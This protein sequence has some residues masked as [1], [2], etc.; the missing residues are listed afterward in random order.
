MKT[1][2][3]FTF[4]IAVLVL[5]SV[6]GFSQVNNLC[7][8]ADPFCT[9]TTYNFPAGV[10]AGTAEVG[11]NYG[12]LYSQ[13]NPAW[14]Y[15]QV[16][17]SGPIEIYMH[18][19][20]N[21]DIDFACWGPFTSPTAPCVAQLTAG[22]NTP[23]HHAPGASPDYPSGN[24]IDCSYSAS[25]EEWCYIPNAVAGQYYILMITNYSNS[26]Q[27]IIFS[28]TGGAGATNCG[29]LAPPIVGDTVCEG[30]TIQ[31]TVTNPTPG[32]SYSWT[33]PGGWTSSVMNPTIPASTLAMSG[34]YSMI[35]TVGTQVSPA[36]TCTVV[37]NPNP[38]ISISP[39]NPSTCSGTAINLTG[40]STTGGTNYS[41]SNGSGTNPNPVNPTTPTTYTVT[42]TDANGCTGTASVQVNINPDLVLSVTP[43]A[44]M[45]CIG[46]SVDLT[47]SGADD[48]AWAPSSGLSCT[49]C[50]FTTAS[51]VTTTTYVVFGSDVN[52]CTGSTS[53]T[54]TAS[55][56]P[57]IQITQ[58]DPVIC[59][60]DTSSLVVNGAANCTWSPVYGLNT[61]SGNHVLAYPLNTT[62]YTVT[63]DNNGCIGTGEV[64]VTV[65]MSP[66][67][68][69]S[70]DVTEGCEK[71]WVSFTDNTT[72][73]VH[74][75]FWNF[76]DNTTANSSNHLQ[77]PKH[78]FDEPGSYDVT[79]SVV[80][81]DGCAGSMTIPQM[82][83]IHPDPI[84]DFIYNPMV[85]DEL[86]Q[87]I[88]FGDQSV[89]ASTW[90]WDFGE[91]YILGNTSNLPNPTHEYDGVGTYWVTLAIMS[92]FGC[93]DTVVK[94][95]V[96]EPLITFYAP[97]SFTPN[98][99]GRNDIFQ[100][101]GWGL[102]E[103]TFEIRI[104]DRWGTQVYF[105][106]DINSGWDGRIQGQDKVCPEG[107]YS[108]ILSV[109][110]VKGNIHKHKGHINL[111]R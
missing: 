48:Y 16:L 39:A 42:G 65:S 23:T 98:N 33:G 7:S 109:Y 1:S 63:G 25:Y 21:Y 36:V 85:T 76:G 56:G 10:N 27:N 106:P 62:T 50:S 69:F 88:W 30:Q 45:I 6:T 77:N 95:V 44:P 9:G 72:P 74:E 75:W 80:S 26:S 8:N 103:S 34:T 79:L 49:D 102:N 24:M 89:N 41:W 37:V 47:A 92:E 15:M 51:P 5:L 53:V 43:S 108:Y 29:I 31:L 97:N 104:Y 20:S 11:A 60:G 32:A 40:N 68:D 55:P 73:P 28:Q 87:F 18:G 78:L 14:Y 58:T 4:L 2:L 19:S 81:D 35:I 93:V 86:D 57:N 54:V 99:D 111:I 94:P 13:P 52:G 83:T 22:S 61:A 105:S 82:I 107:L 64:T 101:F 3:K 110:D 96:I 59:R 90:S 71:L 17:T 12:C 70:A 67:V 66:V 84:A 100:V 91:D 46:G 38:T